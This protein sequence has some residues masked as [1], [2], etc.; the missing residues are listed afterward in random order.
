[1]SLTSL[2]AAP[3]SK[4]AKELAKLGA[5]RRTLLAQERD[6][7]T[8]LDAAKAEHDRLERV[9]RDGEAKARALGQDDP[10]LKAGPKL[11]KLRKAVDTWTSEADTLARAIVA[12]DEEARR[13]V[14]VHCDELV[15]E[16]IASH[17]AA[18]ARITE[19]CAG[20]DTQ[21]AALKAAYV[22]VQSVMAAAGRNA[23]T[24][25]MR[26]PPAVEMLVREGGAPPL[27]HEDDRALVA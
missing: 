12:L 18:R 23:E 25:R 24:S 17:D 10:S 1:M 2:F 6:A 20:L 26:V 19:L 21:A 11:D 14:M 8:A 9:I 15:D 5:R 27:L 16:A 3:Q 22:Q 7:L 13:V 4:P